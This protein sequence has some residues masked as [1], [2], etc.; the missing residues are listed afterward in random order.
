M[1]VTYSQLTKLLVRT[2]SGTELGHVHDVVLDVDS[3]A[4]VQYI[5]TSGMIR[6]KTYEIAPKQILSITETEMIVEDTLT[7]ILN[8]E[9]EQSM[10]AGA[11]PV[12]L[13]ETE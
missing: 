12:M 11:T 6:T 7:P 9:V 1:R 8:E 2:E 5:L 4:A 13:V 10:P 3:H